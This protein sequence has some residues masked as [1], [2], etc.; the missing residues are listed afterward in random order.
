MVEMKYDNIYWQK[1]SK[2]DLDKRCL[3]P[4][5]EVEL[6]PWLARLLLY[7]PLGLSWHMMPLLEGDPIRETVKHKKDRNR[8]RLL[9][10]ARDRERQRETARDRE[11]Q[12]ETE[13]GRAKR[14]HTLIFS[15]FHLTGS[16]TEHLLSPQD[17]DHLINPLPLL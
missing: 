15:S 2:I 13:R 14:K 9:E 16:E 5:Q 11:R 7:Q 6:W 12:L 10:T 3:I 17:G 1:Q 8:K 4:R